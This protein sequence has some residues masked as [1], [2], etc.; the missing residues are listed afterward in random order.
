MSK[1]QVNPHAD[2]DVVPA[3]LEDEMRNAYLDYSMSVIV[4]R[5]LPDVR[6]G[7]KPVHRRILYSMHELGLTHSG[8]YK[9]SARVVGDVLGKYHP[10]GDSAVYDALVRMA[11]DFSLRYP[12]VD[13]Q[14]NYGSIDGDAAA[15]MRYTE[16]KMQKITQEMLADIDQDAVDF[17]EN[18]DG[19]MEEP[20]L[21]PSKF[22]N[23]LVNGSTGIAVGMATNI[24]PHNLR[25]TCQA[26]ISLI[27][28]PDCSNVDLMEDVKGPDFPTGGV[29]M[30]TDGLREAYTT[31]RGKVTISSKFETEEEDDDV[32]LVVTEIPYMVQ[33]S[34][35]LE[36]TAKLVREDKVDGIREIRDESD[37]HGL[38]IV[39]ELKRD[40]QPEIVKNKLLKYSRFKETFGI[41]LL[42][43]VDN[44]P[45]VLTLKGMLNEFLK[46]RKN[47]VRRRLEY[48][49]GNAEDRL[50]ILDG[51]LIALDHIDD[52]IELIRGSE[53]S[54]KARDNLQERYEL[55]EDQA[56]AILKMRLSRLAKLESEEIESEHET[57]S[58]RVQ[59][60]R[61]I[62]GDENEILKVIKEEM[63][64][65]IEEYGDERRTEISDHESGDINIEDLIEDETVVITR[66]A[67]GY[68]KRLPLDTYKQQHR[69]GVGVIGTETKEGDSLADVHITTAKS[70]LLCI[71]NK[72]QLYWMKAYEVPVSGRYSK[73]KPLVNFIDLDDDEHVRSIVPCK[74][75]NAEDYLAFI[76]QNGYVKR[77]RLDAFS[78]P[79]RGGIR[80]VKVE[81]D[82]DLVRAIRTTGDQQ[83]V[84]AT[85]HGNAIRFDETDARAMGRTA[86]GVI[87]VELRDDDHV[88]DASAGHD[89]STILT[90]MESGYGKRTDLDKYR[91]IN[92]GGYGVKNAELSDET[93]N[94]VISRVVE[95]DDELLLISEDGMIIRVNAA[96]ISKYGRATRGVTVMKLQ[97]DDNVKGIAEV[98]QDELEESE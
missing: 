77:T 51:L 88:V 98:P 23:L 50:H 25:E 73:G 32:R 35:L 83:I 56:R 55:S 1:I 86:R 66:S 8:N 28:D 42:G 82:D 15:Q 29:L 94:V 93:G 87:G 79:R 91:L 67:E 61:E 59:E 30:N 85:A 62:L 80:A 90:V 2:D 60:I 95:D 47:V 17:T 43:L 70:Y 65:I 3:V 13:G 22:P 31:G 53:S 6:D 24:P 36:G 46:H 14:G 4:G 74:D 44:E 5:A 81:D 89:D 39:I 9:K 96:E 16:S 10:H 26:V 37:R 69:G 63:E 49:L 97:D 54:T 72:G 34:K 48:E 18:F 76:S 7:L 41:I 21:L 71:T 68:V 27:E 84:I 75:L 64:Y 45:Q 19:S 58:E 38:R 33:K 78:R 12:L 52:V 40:A 92:R 11:Q 57:L 20:E